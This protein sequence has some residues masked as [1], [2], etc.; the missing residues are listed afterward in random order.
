M[1]P[2]RHSSPHDVC[3]DS[4]LAAGEPL[5]GS[6]DQ[7]DA[8]LLLEYRGEWADK[9]IADNDLDAATN[10]WLKQNLRDLVA[11]GRR[12]R[13]LFVRQQDARPDRVTLMLSLSGDATPRL[14]RF[15]FAG[16]GELAGV[17]LA[18]C[19]R[20][21][22]AMAHA[23]AAEPHYLV[24]TNARRDA[25][26]ARY[27]LP[28]YLALRER[29][30]E[31]VWQCTHVGGHRFAPNVLYLPDGVLYGRVNAAELENFVA[32]VEAGDVPRRWL[33]GRTAWPFH[34]QAAEAMIEQGGPL[35]WV[36]DEQLDDARWRVRFA[37]SVG[38]HDVVV[39]LG[40]P[41]DVLA[42]CRD[43]TPKAIRPFVRVR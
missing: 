40:E 16:Y 6:A 4:A 8:W 20:D 32:R 43:D 19:V 13:L 7:V 36:D 24:C 26:C 15:E 18:Q 37:S 22:E 23:L 38:E 14:Y 11:L 9:A 35:R 27:G 12:P 41:L 2:Q 21:P 10:A 28:V 34:V 25:C 29:F 31:R 30:G 42:S 1:A 3:H 17:A 5:W 39:A 33:R